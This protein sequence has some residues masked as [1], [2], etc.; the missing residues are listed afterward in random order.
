MRW[1][2]VPALGVPGGNSV[3]CVGPALLIG[4]RMCAL[5][6]EGLNGGHILEVLDGLRCGLI[7]HISIRWTS[8]AKLPFTKAWSQ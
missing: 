2:Y 7:S 6:L 4:L 8:F 1:H 3:R 5:H